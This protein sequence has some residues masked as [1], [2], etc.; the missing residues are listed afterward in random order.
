MHAI[1]AIV[2]SPDSHT[3]LVNNCLVSPLLS[4]DFVFFLDMSF[5]PSILCTI[6]VSFLYGD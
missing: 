3:Q 4:D 2:N 6:A 5:F 1:D